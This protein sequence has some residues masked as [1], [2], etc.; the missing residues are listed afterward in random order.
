MKR[1]GLLR[2]VEPWE[3]A[4]GSPAPFGAT[5]L[6]AEQAWNFAI[7]SR[8][9]A[10]LTLLLYADSDLTKPVLERALDPIQNK[11]GPIWHCFI[12]KEAAPRARYFAWRAEGPN[13]PPRG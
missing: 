5:W 7:F 6:E 1:L 4:E 13:E 3:R 12:A 8:H 10:S 2:S 11:S 9:A